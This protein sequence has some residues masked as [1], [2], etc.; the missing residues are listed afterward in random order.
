MVRRQSCEQIALAVEK[1]VASNEER[2]CAALDDACEGCLEVAFAGCF[3]GKKR[4]SFR[5]CRR[6][7]SSHIGFKNWVLGVDEYRNDSG[8][9]YQF[10]QQI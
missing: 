10:V 3:G 5:L 4:R 2:T 9:R 1:S 7:Q 8:V 6:T